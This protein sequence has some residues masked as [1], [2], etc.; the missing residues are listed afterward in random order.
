[1]MAL[2]SEIT[3]TDMK[4]SVWGR[5]QRITVVEAIRVGAMNGAYA[6]Y[7]EN[8]KGSIEAGKLADL[9]VLGR[10]PLRENP[11]FNARHHSG[12]THHGRRAPDVRIIGI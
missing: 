4:G 10:D 8:I 9:V 7:E 5:K 6:S 3:R 2:Q 11:S 1:M 12:G